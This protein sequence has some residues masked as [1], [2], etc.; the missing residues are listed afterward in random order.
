MADELLFVRGHKFVGRAPFGPKEG[1]RL[2]YTFPRSRLGPSGLT[3]PYRV[4]KLANTGFPVLRLLL[5]FLSFALLDAAPGRAENLLIPEEL[6][7]ISNVSGCS[8]V[9]DFYQRP[10]MVNPAHVYGYVSQDEWNSAA[11][12]CKKKITSTKP[13]VLLFIFREDDAKHE[14]AKCPHQ[15]ERADYPGGLS[16]YRDRKTTLNNFRYLD[17][18]ARRGPKGARMKYNAIMSGYDGLADIFYCFRG[19]WLV[20]SVD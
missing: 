6:N 15:I 8:Q 2:S 5:S 14:L 4:W 12:W 17:D 3:R 18:P 11:F 19:K 9:E 20:M 13:Y 16:I 1:D 10:G 7:E